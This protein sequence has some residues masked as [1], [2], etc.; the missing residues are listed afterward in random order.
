MDDLKIYEIAFDDDN[1]MHFNIDADGY[2][3]DGLFR[4]LDPANGVSMELVSIDNGD[5]HPIISEQWENIEQQ[6]KIAATKK[7]N[8]LIKMAQFKVISE[9]NPAPN[10]YQTWIRKAEDIKTFNDTL[11]DNDWEDWE[12][13]GF[14]DSYSAFDVENALKSG[15]IKVYSSHPI[16]QGV[17]VTPSYME[18]YSYSG[19]GKVYSTVVDLDDIAWID[20]TQGQYAPVKHIKSIYSGEVEVYFDG[21]NVSITDK[22][23]RQ[24][25]LQ[26]ADNYSY[27]NFE[28]YLNGISEI[29]PEYRLFIENNTA[30]LISDYNNA[31]QTASN[32]AKSVR[33]AQ[34]EADMYEGGGYGEDNA[35]SRAEAEISRLNEELG[36]TKA[37]ENFYSP[38]TSIYFES[39]KSFDEL[40]IQNEIKYH[41]KNHHFSNI[42][43]TN[44]NLVGDFK[45]CV[46]R[47][48]SFQNFN[49][50]HINFENSSFNNCVIINSNLKNS[51]F[52]HT[53]IAYVQIINSDFS[54]VNFAASKINDTNFEKNN[55]SGV[56]FHGTTLNSVT[57]SEA[58]IDKPIEG[59]YIENITMDGATHQELETNRN[60]I[61]SELE[62]EPVSFEQSIEQLKESQEPL[63]VKEQNSAEL[64]GKQIQFK[65]LPA[66]SVAEYPYNVQVHFKYNFTAEFVYSGMGRFCKNLDE[67]NKYINRIKREYSEYEYKFSYEGVNEN[68]I[69]KLQ[70][71]LENTTSSLEPLSEPEPKTISKERMDELINNMVLLIKNT[72][73]SDSITILKDCGFKE[74]EIK[75]TNIDYS[76]IDENRTMQLLKSTADKILNTSGDYEMG[77]NTLVWE[78]KIT[79]DELKSCGYGEIL[80]EIKEM[81]EL[82]AADDPIANAERISKQ[83]ENDE[84]EGLEAKRVPQHNIKFVWNGI[85]IDGQL[86]KGIYSTGP[87]TETSSLPQGTVS[88]YMDT[89]RTPRDCGLEIKNE[90][91]I[92]TDYFEKDTVLVRPDSKYYSEAATAATAYDIHMEKVAI[93]QYEKGFAKYLGT[94]MEE[95]YANE[96]SKHKAKLSE[97]EKESGKDKSFRKKTVP[98]W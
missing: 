39:Q 67:V 45:N 55:L 25:K 87:Y 97:L 83:I 42:T 30:E 63:S 75:A 69:L 90:S 46:F 11:K 41:F 53:G 35:N 8:E 73:E 92:M 13:N 47:N 43:F 27:N 9:F 84:Y 18:A 33:L 77:F 15:K 96:L 37:I 88:I 81:R 65:I 58:V 28:E 54:N 86:Y 44:E 57:V 4:V 6:C 68:E 82:W 20:P 56:K 1:Y 50:E 26:P 98:Q 49:G 10:E 60:R 38:E 12:I 93:K 74:D 94:D 40:T 76:S 66:N 29:Y 32:E 16:K 24:I 72:F 3:L 23:N 14:D 85:K 59:L 21:D 89:S 80:D 51:N 79:N 5:R 70:S 7:Y 61:F 17:F 48:C 64:N 22:Y 62:L 91:D 31:L 78:A 36:N 34:L 71:E 19:D 52:E 95:Y 2:R